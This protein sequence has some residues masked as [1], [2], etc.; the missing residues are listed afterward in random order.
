MTLEELKIELENSGYENSIVLENP[1]YIDAV[2]GVSQD[3]QV[4]YDFNKM[5]EYLVN[6]DKMEEE[7][8]I[9]FIEYNTIRALPYMGE[10][11]PII[12]FT[13]LNNNL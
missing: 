13:F 7:E 3:G 10:N 6:E 8:A 2:I 11:K 5:V 4:I 12:L 1:S 9:E